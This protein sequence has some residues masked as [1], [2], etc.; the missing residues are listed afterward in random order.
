MYVANSHRDHSHV[1]NFQRHAQVMERHVVAEL[2]RSGQVYSVFHR[3]QALRPIH[4]AVKSVERH[5]SP[6]PTVMCARVVLHL[7]QVRMGM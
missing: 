6:Q 7:E 5:P 1:P 3:F 4:E 2:V